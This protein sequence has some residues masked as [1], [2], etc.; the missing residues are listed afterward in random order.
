MDPGAGEGLANKNNLFDRQIAETKYAH[1]KHMMVPVYFY[2]E[3][4]K[5]GIQLL[6]PDLYFAMD[7][8]PRK[9]VFLRDNIS[10]YGHAKRILADG[11]HPAI[12]YGFENPLYMCEF[13]FHLEKN[14]AY[15]HVFMPKGA[16]PKINKKAKFYPRISPLSYPTKTNILAD[17][18]NRK[19]LT[20]INGNTRLHFLRR[21]YVNFF[22]IKKPFPSLVNREM[23]V[24]R[25]NAIKFFSSDPNFDLYGR[26]WDRPVRYTRAYDPFIKKSYRGKIPDK[27]PVLEKYKFS[28]IFE[29]CIFDGW[30]TEKIVDSMYAGCVPIY[31]GAPDITD[32]VPAN[33]FIDY[34]KFKDFSELDYF[35]KNMDEKTFS[36]YVENI[37]SFFSSSYYYDNFSKE[38]FIGD[39]V[40]ILASYI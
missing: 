40:K 37:N 6:T 26:G 31:W 24:E 5:R 21:L 2:E 12:L 9:I 28:L 27:L 14:T 10:D 35:L 8:K 11:V 30:I 1:V 20:I 19:H 15:D 38:K 4:L 23:Y 17:F 13:Y 32:Y 16:G 25:L 22:N 18:K 7:P 33:C 36:Q 39:T 29:N 3:S 34:R